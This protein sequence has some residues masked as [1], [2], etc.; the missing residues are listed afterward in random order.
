M[1]RT[2]DA[3]PLPTR[4]VAAVAVG[5]QPGSDSSAPLDPPRLGSTRRLYLASSSW[6]GVQAQCALRVSTGLAN[7]LSVRSSSGYSTRGHLG[8]DS[9]L[10]FSQGLPVWIYCTCWIRARSNAHAVRHGFVGAGPAATLAHSGDP[11]PLSHRLS[12]PGATI[13]PGSPPSFLPS[14][15]PLAQ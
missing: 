3:S 12:R 8:F 11:S 15:H 14:A 7:Q 1:T 2:V 5:P 6:Q 10:K 13:P 9:L 4:A